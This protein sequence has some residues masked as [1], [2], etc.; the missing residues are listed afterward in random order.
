M[1]LAAVLAT[2]VSQ[3]PQPQAAWRSGALAVDMDS[4]DT[5]LSLH[6][7]E[8]FRP[9]STVKLVTT[10]LAF[11]TLGPSRVVT[12][13]V[14]ADTSAS[15][16]RIT[17]AGAPL[18]EPDDLERAAVETAAFL[19][20]GRV[21]TLY[22]DTSAFPDSNR[23][24][25]WSPSDWTKAYCPPVEAL[26]LGDNVLELVVSARGGRVELSWYPEIPGLQVRGSV[27]LGPGEVTARPGGWEGGD[28]VV[29]VGGSIA[30]DSVEI[31][32]VPFA[33]APGQFAA[34]FAGELSQRRVPVERI[35]P[36]TGGGGDWATAAVMRSRPVYDLAAQM[37]RWS[38]NFVAELILR[39]C[40]EEAWG[41][42]TTASGCEMA[43]AMLSEL[44]PADGAQLADGSG[45]S[46]L[47]R[48]T[49]GQLVAVLREGA[50]SPEWGPEFLASLAVNGVDGTLGS[51]LADLPPGVFRGKTGTLSDTAALAGILLTAGGRRV[52]LALVS[53]VPAGAVH[54]ARNWQDSV[55]RQLYACH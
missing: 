14:E 41:S 34:I 54:S 6:G 35:L 44:A 5:L 53:E 13:P 9:A 23:C 36:G 48:L 17:G 38:V 52:A 40:A 12:T 55:V 1:L 50:G 22:Y 49:P 28:P 33:D 26:N 7:D 30:R 25:G 27:A 51:R 20:E 16:I 37:N 11:R 15:L 42:G 3:F 29:T 10:L 4:G 39:I 47:D 19:P 45:L 8:L 46:R 24:P 18:I 43:G 31:L 32:Y 21:W 2:L